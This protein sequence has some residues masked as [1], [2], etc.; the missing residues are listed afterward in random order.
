MIQSAAFRPFVAALALALAPALGWAAPA[1]PSAPDKDKAASPAEKIR[2]ALNAPVTVKVE[3]QSL[4]AAIDVLKAKGKINFSIDT[5]SI[6]Q[7]GWLPDQPPTPVDVDLK[8]VKLKSALRTIL[9]PYNLSYAVV[10]DTVVVTTEPMA[11]ARQMKQRVNVEFEKVEFATALKQLSRDTGANLLLDSRIEKEAKNAVSLELDDVPLE[12][13]V[14][15][16]SE[17]AGLKPVRIGNVL[18]ITEKKN[19][20]ELRNDPDLAPPAGQPG[21]PNVLTESGGL[22]L[23]GGGLAP[24]PPAVGIGTAPAVPAVPAV[25]PAVED[26]PKSDPAPEKKDDK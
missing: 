16:L 4:T 23:P 22:A 20:A 9:D 25:P 15:L 8:D 14:R 3:K 11:V 12:T 18:F 13:A 10:G 5:F 1:A 26:K 19:A 17:M 21:N 7:L 6:Q 24:P 2:Q